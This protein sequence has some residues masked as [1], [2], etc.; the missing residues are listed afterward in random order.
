MPAVWGISCDSVSK[1]A[2]QLRV[3]LQSKCAGL[4]LDQLLENSSIKRADDKSVNKNKIK[5]SPACTL[6]F[7]AAVSIV[8]SLGFR[9]PE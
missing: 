3:T 8:L 9:S 1:R 7:A 2:F 4:S 6:F 5:W